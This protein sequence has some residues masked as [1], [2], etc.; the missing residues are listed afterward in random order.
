[1]IELLLPGW[2]AGMLLAMATG[3]LGSFVVWRRM[4]YFGDTLAHASL[5]GVAFGLLFNIEPFYAVIAVTLLLAILLVWLELKPQ[6]SVDTLLGIMAHS[7]LSLGLVVVSLMSNVRVDLMAYL[8]G[9]LLSVNYQ[10]VLSIFIGVVIVL[11]VILRSW[12]PLLS[13]TINQDMAFVDGVNIQRERL[14]LMMIT[15]LTIGLAMK[16]V[17]ALIITSL[18]IIPAATARRFARSPEQ[19]ALIAVVVG[20][21]AIT[22]GLTFSAF[23]DTPAG[24]SVV[25]AAS[26][27]FILSLFAP[28]KQ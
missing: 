21:L 22:G 3:P 27:L 9:D 17:G 5:L 23:Y 26:C 4:S 25:L 1:M 16:F 12:R 8:F 10:D 13:M 15:A 2:I 24:P 19:M 18:L 11:F 14:K 7:A 20:M 6:L 28:T